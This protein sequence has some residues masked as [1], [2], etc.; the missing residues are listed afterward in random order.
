M[1]QTW[2][3]GHDSSLVNQHGIFGVVSYNG[4]SRFM[5]GCDDLVL[6][7]YFCTPSLRALRNNQEN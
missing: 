6:L 5:V 7:V 3:S 1:S 4:M 2:A